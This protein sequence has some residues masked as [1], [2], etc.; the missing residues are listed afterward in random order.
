PDERYIEKKKAAPESR[1]SKLIPEF[2]MARSGLLAGIVHILLGLV[3]GLL[4]FCLGTRGGLKLFDRFAQALLR[5]SNH[6][7]FQ[8]IEG[9]AEIVRDMHRGHELSQIFESLGVRL[10]H[11]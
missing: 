2:S 11:R 3:V 5:R 9:N 7:G 1:L 8:L 6:L 4:G 10:Q